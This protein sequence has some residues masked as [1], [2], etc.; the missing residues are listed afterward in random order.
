MA[1]TIY[2]W[3]FKSG[4][5]D[6]LTK[7]YSDN[8]TDY[9]MSGIASS[10]GTAPSLYVSRITIPSGCSLALKGPIKAGDTLK[11]NLQGTKY[12]NA[13]VDGVE[14][15]ATPI[16]GTSRYYFNLTI[17]AEN[18]K[19][20]EISITGGTLSGGD[21]LWISSAEYAHLD[22]GGGGTGGGGTTETTGKLLFGSSEITKVYLGSTEISKLCIGSTIL[23]ENSMAVTSYKY[24]LAC[25]YKK[26]YFTAY[27]SDINLGQAND[28]SQALPTFYDDAALTIEH[29][30]PSTYKDMAWGFQYGEGNITFVSNGELLVYKITNDY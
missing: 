30:W 14:I 29:K 7:M 20:Q 17:T 2:T 13:V 15:L 23:Y 6:D 25:D 11:L 22:S 19:N 8:G 18:E 16:E 12:K 21:P 28:S 3:I 9:Y 4:A 10:D 24:D 5:Y 1:E 26:D 27:S